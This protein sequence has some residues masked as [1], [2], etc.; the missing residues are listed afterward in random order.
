[1]AYFLPILPL[2]MKSKAIGFKLG[3]KSLK[4][5]FEDKNKLLGVLQCFVSI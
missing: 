3:F 5:N 1:M 2:T 4:L